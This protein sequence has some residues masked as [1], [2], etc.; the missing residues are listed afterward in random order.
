[1]NDVLLFEKLKIAVNEIVLEYKGLKASIE[2]N[3][4]YFI[5]KNDNL[6]KSFVLEYTYLNKLNCTN[7]LVYNEDVDNEFI[8]SLSKKLEEKLIKLFNEINNQEEICEC[9]YC[10]E[11]L[12]NQKGFSNELPVWIC[13]RCENYVYGENLKFPDTIWF[14]DKCDSL[15]NNQEGFSDKISK[16]SCKNCGY[17]NVLSEDKII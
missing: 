14:C 9:P 10:G 8:D 16:Y 5:L 1:M 3:L 2:K 11:T 4:I 6:Y 17:E 13:K 12:N 7:K 15:L